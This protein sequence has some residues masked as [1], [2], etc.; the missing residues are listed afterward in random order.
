[1]TKNLNHG[2]DE[3]PVATECRSKVSRSSYWKYLELAYVN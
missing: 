2:F 1:M 3:S